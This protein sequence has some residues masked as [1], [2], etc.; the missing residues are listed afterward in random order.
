MKYSKDE[1]QLIEK[2]SKHVES[3]GDA[4]SYFR[5]V[6]SMLA[7]DMVLCNELDAQ[8]HVEVPRTKP[9]VY[10]FVGEAGSGKT[11]CAMSLRALNDIYVKNVND[12]WWDG[13]KASTKLVILDDLD[14]SHATGL[15]DDASLKRLLD[16][17]PLRVPTKGSSVNFNPEMIIITSAKTPEALYGKGGTGGLDGNRWAQIERRI[18]QVWEFA[19]VR[20]AVTVYSK[21]IHI[22]KRLLWNN[23]K[24]KWVTIA[25][26]GSHMERVARVEKNNMDIVHWLKSHK[27]VVDVPFAA[28]Q[29]SRGKIN[30]VWSVLVNHSGRELGVG[31]SV[32]LGAKGR[33]YIPGDMYV[34]WLK[35]FA[36]WLKT[37]NGVGTLPIYE[38]PVYSAADEEA[39]AVEPYPMYIDID[40]KGLSV[41]V[42]EL[43]GAVWA[44]LVKHAGDT[45]MGVRWIMAC[46]RSQASTDLD[47]CRVDDGVHIYQ[48]NAEGPFLTY[49]EVKDL[50]KRMKEDHGSRLNTLLEASLTEEELKNGKGFY[51]VQAATVN[52]ALL[53]TGKE[54]GREYVPI[55]SCYEEEMDGL[56]G[57]V[58]DLLIETSRRVI[59][60]EG[61]ERTNTNKRDWRW[62]GVPYK[63]IVNKFELPG[64]DVV[65]ELWSENMIPDKKE[66]DVPVGKGVMKREDRVALK[67]EEGREMLIENLKGKI[68]Q[69]LNTEGWE[70]MYKSY[71][72]DK[73]DGADLKIYSTK[74]INEV[75]DFW[76]WREQYHNLTRVRDN[77]FKSN[78]LNLEEML[79][80]ASSE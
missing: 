79:K 68:D 15:W 55:F 22:R 71:V 43:W 36:R 24:I 17:Y 61:I 75:K 4:R 27:E 32:A 53:Y 65:P 1:S 5:S 10:W 3:G 11:S 76:I 6:N 42:L 13:F 26:H 20:D 77:K 57:S 16:R 70:A 34:D 80:D 30:E 54:L 78:V 25:D 31:E 39:M 29:K 58:E 72:L 2:C 52:I 73:R 18:D 28:M 49:T 41:P 60:G 7:Y 35:M 64:F 74:F 69:R 21:P 44:D 37:T 45:F 62:L 56:I 66:E 23:G 51:D 9:V 33:W 47:T 12:A 8:W 46:H 67:K 59:E 48:S 19:P 50:L 63:E 38:S 14:S 40:W